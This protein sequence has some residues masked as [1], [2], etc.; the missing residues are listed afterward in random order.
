MFLE[1]IDPAKPNA[2]IKVRSDGSVVA[3]G[4]QER[5]IHPDTAAAQAR[6]AKLVAAVST[7]DLLSDFRGVDG[8]TRQEVLQGLRD[9]IARLSRLLEE[10]LQIATRIR[11]KPEQAE[12]R[13]RDLAANTTAIQRVEGME[14]RAG[15]DTIERLARGHA[16]RNE[17]IRELTESRV[18]AAT[19]PRL[20]ELLA[21]VD[22]KAAKEILVDEVGKPMSRNQQRKAWRRVESRLKKQERTQR[23]AEAAPKRFGAKAKGAAW[24]GLALEAIDIAGPAIEGYFSSRDQREHED[25]YMFFRD[26]VW[27]YEKGI[28]MP[29]TGRTEDGEPPSLDASIERRLYD[30]TDAAQRAPLTTEGQAATPL[31]TLWIRELNLWT[32][33]ERLAFFDTLRHWLSAHVND[34]EDYF[35]ELKTGVTCPDSAQGQCAADRRRDLA[36]P[37]RR[38]QRRPRALRMA[39]LA[40]AKQDPERD[41]SPGV[42]RTEAAIETRIEKSK[43]FIRSVPQTTAGPAD[44]KPGTTFSANDDAIIGRLKV[45]AKRAKLYGV[46]N[47]APIELEKKA[48]RGT[49]LHLLELARTPPK[50]SSGYVWVTAADANSYYLLR[51]LTTW[52]F[53]KEVKIPR[54]VQNRDPSSPNF[55]PVPKDVPEKYM[56]QEELTAWNAFQAGDPG[57]SFKEDPESSVFRG[58]V[59]ISEQGS[60][61][62]AAVLMKRSDLG[63]DE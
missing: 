41:R 11:D 19:S 40:G 14:Q 35:A 46:K 57:Y 54:Y 25:F 17:L 24:L 29:L 60:N 44:T 34:W 47:N 3:S 58:T 18:K 8:A 48:E 28:R 55:E 26:A 32:A 9:E 63:P 5:G 2:N 15:R 6:L 61:I 51:G 27:W 50:G 56:N 4:A 36:D 59:T 20:R 22:P 1:D 7:L 37:R 10:R 49:G 45:T 21:K 39:R 12:Q 13:T 31:K 43:G 33:E 52:R 53:V 62:G 38:A 16:E 30:D 23:I 42:R